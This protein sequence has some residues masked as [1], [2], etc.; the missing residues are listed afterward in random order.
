MIKRVKLPSDALFTGGNEEYAKQE[1]YFDMEEKIVITGMGAVTP[2]GIGVQNFWE[3]LLSGTCGISKIERE[4]CQGL[5]VQIAGQVKNFVPENYMPKKLVR[6]TDVFMQYAFAAA[7]EAMKDS[8]IEDEEGKVREPV[9]TGIVMAT[10]MGGIAEIEATH[11]QMTESKHKNVSPRFV[12]KILGNVSAAQI[13]IAKN[14]HGP[15]LTVSTA[16]SS[17]GDAVM[18][19]AMLIKSGMA[20]VVVVTGGEAAI[21][22]VFVQGLTGA[23]ALSRR[24]DEPKRASRPFDADRD[25]F[26]MGEGGGAV[27]LESERHAKERGAL[28]YAELAGCA[29]NTDAYHVTA[30]NPDG[31]GA[32][33]C[34]EKAIAAAGIKPEEIGY[35]NAH[36]TSTKAGDI[37]ETKA[38][39]KVF[40]DKAGEVSISS[41]KGATGHLMGAGGIVEVIVC[42]KALNDQMMPPTLNLE[43]PDSECDLDYVPNTA[44]E[45][46]FSYAMSNA[47]GFGGQNSSII[48]KKYEK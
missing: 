3:N 33:D 31:D 5:A 39:K 45:K 18:V 20:D 24:N 6:E 41:T 34:M 43:K 15:S 4:D 26:V 38:I 16:C 25:G 46:K 44:R 48:V 22:P 35:I 17:G 8:G 9:R 30:P 47:F 23:R 21:C 36:G 32:A 13:S 11:I 40:K 7:C 29:N 28:I 2:V 12:P 19:G 27:I 42:V 1:G 37:A 14:I 10:A